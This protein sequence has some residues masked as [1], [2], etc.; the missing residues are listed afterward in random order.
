MKSERRHELETNQLAQS[1]ANLPEMMRLYGSRILLAVT[2]VILVAV[3]VYTRISSSRAAAV[4]AV[5]TLAYSRE[6]LASLRHFEPLALN[7]PED[8]RDTFRSYVQDVNDA[9]DVVVRNTDDPKLL[10]EALVARGDLNWLIATYP[11]LPEATTRPA[12]QL[13][14]NRQAPLNIAFESYSNVLNAYPNQDMPVLS[15]RFGLAAIAENRGDWDTARS[16]YQAVADNDR[17]PES[18]RAEA[19]NRIEQLDEVSQP[20]LVVDA[21]PAAPDA[22]NT[23]DANADETAPDNAPAADDTPVA[24]TT[25]P[26]AD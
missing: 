26:A 7:A 12:L 14:D 6:R 4:E 25:Q 9:L 24:P 2:L 13:H 22:P 20:I 3:F 23:S 8:R 10:A 16:H 19:R 17:F 5:N 18:F 1:L 21:L 15:A 11:E